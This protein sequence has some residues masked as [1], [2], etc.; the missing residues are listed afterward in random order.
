MELLIWC[1]GVYGIL[2]YA[3]YLSFWEKNSP[4]GKYRFY[5]S[6]IYMGCTLMAFVWPAQCSIYIGMLVAVGAA[7]I[8]DEILRRI[9][10][11]NQKGEDT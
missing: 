10:L 8:L 5:S 7:L 1:L 4:L 6:L 11:D 9:M 3:F 2:V